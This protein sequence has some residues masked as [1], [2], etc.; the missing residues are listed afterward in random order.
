MGLWRHEPSVYRSL[1]AD[2]HA[3]VRAVVPPSYCRHQASLGVAEAGPQNSDVAKGQFPL[4]PHHH[5]S[6]KINNKSDYYH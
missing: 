5:L 3:P 4:H 2:E 6:T 1:S